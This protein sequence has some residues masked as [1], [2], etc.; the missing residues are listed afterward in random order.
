MRARTL[1]RRRLCRR[2]SLTS[3]ALFV[4]TALVVVT[5]AVLVFGMLVTVRNAVAYAAIEAAR[6]AAKGAPLHAVSGRDVLAVVN[7]TLEPH[8]VEVDVTN[9][10]DP[11]TKVILEDPS[12]A[13]TPQSWGGLSCSPPTDPA[14]DHLDGFV[15]VTVGVSTTSVPLANQ[16]HKFGLSFVGD[17]LRASAV[18]KRECP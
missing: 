15:R 6:E 13:L 11:D 12:A 5:I 16:L 3:E 17:L 10:N 4:L 2:A 8:H 18:V 7:Y 9:S 14:F 1:P